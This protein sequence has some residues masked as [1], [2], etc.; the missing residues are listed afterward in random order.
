ME[1]HFSRHGSPGNHEL[2][3]CEV[4][5]PNGPPNTSR[6]W[7]FTCQ[8][9]HAHLGWRLSA[10]CEY[11]SLALLSSLQDWNVPVAVGLHWGIENARGTENV[12]GNLLERKRDSSEAWRCRPQPLQSWI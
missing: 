2:K 9:V 7:S 11:I 12:V 3:F 10:L 1:A 6:S 5:I 8:C 4:V